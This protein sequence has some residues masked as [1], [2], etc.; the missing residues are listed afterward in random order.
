MSTVTLKDALPSETQNKLLLLKE[1]T[2][3]PKNDRTLKI[4]KQGQSLSVATEV[5]AV[6]RS[7]PSSKTKGTDNR[8]VISPQEQKDREQS[9]EL[10]RQTKAW[11][12]STFPKAF[13]FKE[14]KPLKLG[15]QTELLLV[16]SPY[17]KTQLRRCLGSYCFSRAYLESILHENSRYGLNGEK[18]EGISQEHKDRATKELAERKKKFQHKQARPHKSGHVESQK[19]T[20]Q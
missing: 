3:N 10:F 5:G 11:L 14:P 4:E 7:L 19:E 15:I 17:S 16:S 1:A 6:P 12:E 9:K 8:K 20:S 13:N 2:E 18:V